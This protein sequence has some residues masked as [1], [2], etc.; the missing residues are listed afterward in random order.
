MN[1]EE[2][3]FKLMRFKFGVPILLTMLERP[4]ISQ[5]QLIHILAGEYPSVINAL[6]FMS[7]HSFITKI[8]L[9]EHTHPR[10]EYVLSSKGRRMALSIKACAEDM[11]A[12]S[13]EDHHHSRPK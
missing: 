3:P 11:I 4:K 13:S 5:G 12:I 1:F 7:E 9:G 10:F 8:D 2:I 6:V